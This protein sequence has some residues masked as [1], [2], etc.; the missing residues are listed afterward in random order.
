MFWQGFEYQL[1]TN[2]LGHFLLSHLLLPLL[3]KSGEGGKP[4]R[5]V[6]FSTSHL[7]VAFNDYKVVRLWI[8]STRSNPFVAFNDDKVV[9]LLL[10]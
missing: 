1:C 10:R 8:A 5:L 9:S 3:I 6:T 7:L 4:A 2:Y